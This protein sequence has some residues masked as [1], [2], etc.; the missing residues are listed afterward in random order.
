MKGP[1]KSYATT[2]GYEELREP[3]ELNGP[4][5]PGWQP[6][7]RDQVFALVQPADLYALKRGE[8]VRVPELHLQLRAASA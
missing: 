5:E 8:V 4:L 2:H 6:I 1:A 7:S 3:G